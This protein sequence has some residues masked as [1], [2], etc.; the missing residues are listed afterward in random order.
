MG[1]T[2]AP[3]ANA[4]STPT[5]P[6]VFPSVEDGTPSEEGAPI[7]RNGFN[8]QDEIAVGYLLDMQEDPSIQKVHCETH[9]DVI[10]I[11][12]QDASAQV[13]MRLAVNLLDGRVFLHVEQIAYRDLILVIE[14]IARDW[15]PPLPME[16]HLRQKER[17]LEAW[18]CLKRLLLAPTWFP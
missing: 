5:P 18:E 10:L 17:L 6:K 16:C 12:Q 11:S 3:K 15:A 7:A 8:Y 14:T 13:I 4:S 2:S 9:D 1:T